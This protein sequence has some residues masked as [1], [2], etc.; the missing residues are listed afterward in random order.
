MTKCAGTEF[1]AVIYVSKRN[2]GSGIGS[3]DQKVKRNAVVFEV[4]IV[5][6]QR[7]RRSPEGHRRIDVP[8]NYL[9]LN[10]N[11]FSFEGS[12]RPARLRSYRI[13]EKI[14]VVSYGTTRIFKTFFI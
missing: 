3:F 10:K 13:R 1:S 9:K 5:S 12:W 14:G 6:T 8:L 2:N 11:L 4:D 7:F